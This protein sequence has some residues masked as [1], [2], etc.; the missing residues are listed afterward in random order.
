MSSLQSVGA[1]FNVAS[2]SLTE[3]PGRRTCPGVLL[4]VGIHILSVSF[5]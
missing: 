3:S 1:S 2:L 4:L 5:L